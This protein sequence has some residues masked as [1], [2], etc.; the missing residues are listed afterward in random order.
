MTDMRRPYLDNIR[1][2]TVLLVIAYHVCYLFNGVGV[3]GGIP[4]A[5]SIP[6]LDTAAGIV[7]PWFMVLLFAV[8]GISARY[9][10]EQKTV[11]QFLRARRDK[12]LIPSTLGLFPVHWVTGY[13][14]LRLAGALAYLPASLVYP[15][16]V[17]SGIGPLW[18]AQ[19]LFLFSCLLA[20]IRRLDRQDRLVCKM[21]HPVCL[22]LLFLPLWGASHL[23]NLP[24]LTMYRFGIYLTAF[25]IGY[26]ILSQEEAQGALER[27]CLPLLAGALAGG[28][29]HGLRWRGTDYTAPACLQSFLTNLYLWLAV[30][31]I[32]GCGRRYLNRETAL[33]RFFNRRSFG[34]YV[35][36]YP[37]L[38]TAC[39]LLH[40]GG[41]SPAVHYALALASGLAGSLALYELIR[42]LPVLRYLVLGERGPHSREKIFSR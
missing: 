15:V 4:N 13:W 11:G 35:L 7:Y 8:A 34:L 2:A 32:L 22:V 38:I 42:R 40:S 23:L 14:N 12:L 25:L 27:Y 19:M 20:L 36:H 24:V 28:V 1:W 39:A 30:L 10:L 16:A 6:A 18:F 26:L 5:E 33:T 37:V 29:I 9:A 21:E 3:P 17:L 41:G 31:A